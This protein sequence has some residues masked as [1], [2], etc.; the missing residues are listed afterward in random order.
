[1]FTSH[2]L[3]LYATLLALNV[4][5]GN[6]Y[7][8]SEVGL[9]FRNHE[10]QAEEQIEEQTEEERW[11]AIQHR[12]T[13][14]VEPEEPAEPEELMQVTAESIGQISEPATST[15]S[16]GDTRI[17]LS[18]TPEAITVPYGGINTINFKVMVSLD[19]QTRHETDQE[20]LQ[21]LVIGSRSS[22]S[23]VSP[24]ADSIDSGSLQKIDSV[25]PRPDISQ[26]DNWEDMQIKF[27]QKNLDSQIQKEVDSIKAEPLEQMDATQTAA[28]E[29]VTLISHAV[30]ARIAYVNTDKGIGAGDTEEASI[31]QKFA[32][33]G[34]W[35]SGLYGVST[36]GIS[37]DT[38]NNHDSNNI[39][40]RGRS[41]KG[42][43]VGSTIGIDFNPAE[44]SLI[45]IAYSNA[46]SRLKYK[47]ITGELTANS[48]SLSIYG[49]QQVNNFFIQGLISFT[50]SH[51]N[52]ILNK[53]ITSNISGVAKAR[54]N[55][56]ALIGEIITSYKISHQSG[57]VVM[58]NISLRFSGYRDSG[59]TETGA[60]LMNL[61]VQ[62]SRSHKLTGIAGVRFM[63]PEIEASGI[64][65]NL[66]FMPDFNFSIEKYLNNGRPK[67]RAK[68]SWMNNYFDSQISE[69]NKK[70]FGFNL[71]GGLMA[72]RRNFEVFTG[73]NCHLENKYKSHQGSLKIRILF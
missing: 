68:L 5:I 21:T 45:G 15:T 29:T 34:L 4:I 35:I 41:Y 50:L 59:Y 36:K 25:I 18:I 22:L 52:S 69:R 6:A 28:Q 43:V 20:T 46:R 64:A 48:N 10:E 8:S 70:G 16:I 49:Q 62:A 44:E 23:V 55:N 13:A 65:D 37:N 9:P 24:D 2:S 17:T 33:Y 72:K 39:S 53:K 1:M 30:S 60:G 12:D 31:F 38:G 32:P 57:M 63:T 56:T 11:A 26:C 71:G 19:P 73:Y 66:V 67:V 58:P 47:D 14:Q 40:Y 54:F 7:G 27:Y 61:Q 3:A 51:V 42:R